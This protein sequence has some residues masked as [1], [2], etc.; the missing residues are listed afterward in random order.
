MLS[1]S[2]P[3]F[4][5]IYNPAWPWQQ[6]HLG[7]FEVPPVRCDSLHQ[8]ALN[9]VSQL[10]WVLVILR[11]VGIESLILVITARFQ[12]PGAAPC[13]E[14]SFVSVLVHV[15]WDLKGA[16]LLEESHLSAS[17]CTIL[18]TFVL[19]FQVSTHVRCPN[20]LCIQQVVLSTISL[21]K[22]KRRLIFVLAAV[23]KCSP[24][25]VV[26]VKEEMV[27]NYG[28]VFTSLCQVSGITGA[29]GSEGEERVVKITE[30]D[31]GSIPVVNVASTMAQNPITNSCI[32][33]S[34]TSHFHVKHIVLDHLRGDQS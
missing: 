3:S 6:D 11:A 8:L 26:I 18:S 33:I 24:L 5:A 14:D 1:V 20:L 10:L 30:N 29:F 23:R 19:L 7:S 32:P 22:C 31:L 4:R 2:L 13:T 17:V 15:R 25:Q 28:I 27:A 34:T 9:S 12:W 21:W 16:P